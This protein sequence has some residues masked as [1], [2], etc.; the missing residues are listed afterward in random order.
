MDRLCFR[1]RLDVIALTVSDAADL[2]GVSPRTVRRWLTG[3]AQIPPGI[4]AELVA[5]EDDFRGWVSIITRDIVNGRTVLLY[6]DDE[7]FRQLQPTAGGIT[8]ARWRAAT[9]AAL[10]AVAG[11]SARISPE[12]LDYYLY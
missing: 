8:A 3:A 1:V 2:F 6:S 7:V 12:S 5:A 9:T 11:V 4:E 10:W